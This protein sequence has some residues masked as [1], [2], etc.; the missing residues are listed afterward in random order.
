MKPTLPIPSPKEEKLKFIFICNRGES[1]VELKEI[2]QN[3]AFKEVSPTAEVLEKIEPLLKKYKGVVRD[4]FFK[5]L[6]HER[7]SASRY[8]YSS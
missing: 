1:F 3:L 7:Y 5:I 8:V 4:K 2:K 6:P